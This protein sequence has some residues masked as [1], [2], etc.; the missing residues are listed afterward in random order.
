MFWELLTT[1]SKE[2][3]PLLTKANAY[4]KLSVFVKFQIHV[5]HKSNAS[6][7][8]ISLEAMFKQM[9]VTRD[10]DLYISML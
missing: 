1:V 2:G 5:I 6:N 4:T 10:H 8:P 3:L 9:K 7:W